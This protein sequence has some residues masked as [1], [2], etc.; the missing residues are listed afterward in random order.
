MIDFRNIIQTQTDATNPTEHH[1][2]FYAEF[3]DSDITHMVRE[4]AG[5]S[6]DFY[7]SAN[8]H[9]RADWMKVLP[10][11]NLTGELDRIVIVETR[12]LNSHEFQS[13]DILKLPS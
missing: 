11:I 4:L 7:Q 8:H 1:R 6:Q 12:G 3:M 5:P 10:P 9:I 2:I 13:E